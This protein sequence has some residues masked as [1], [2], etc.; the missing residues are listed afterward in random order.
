MLLNKVGRFLKRDLWRIRTKDLPRSHAF[1]ISPLRVVMLAFR[2]FDEDKCQLRA[3]A[4]TFYTLLSM[5]PVAAMAFGIAKGFNF[6]DNLQ[7]LIL[8][9]LEGQEEVATQIIGFANNLLNN[10]SSGLIA[11]IGVAILFWTVIKVLGNIEASFNDIWGVKKSRTMMRKFADYL[12]VMLI[13]PLLLIVSSSATIF[14]ATQVK[15]LVAKMALLGA[16][17]PLILLLLKL[18]PFVVIWVLFTFVYVFM[19]NTKVDFKAGLLGGITAGTIYQIAQWAY[20]TFQIGAS[21]YGAIYG[22]F[23]AL[24][25]FLVWLQISWLIVLLGAEVSFAYQNVETYSFEPDCLEISY[26][27]KRLLTLRIMC[28]AAKRF[29]SGEPPLTAGE[30]T[31][32]LDIP[33]R[34]V[35]QIL[36]ELVAAGLFAEVAP[37]EDKERTFQP[38]RCVEGLT[39]G[40]VMC[41]LEEK[42]STA[43]PVHDSAELRKLRESLAAF[44]QTIKASAANVRLVDV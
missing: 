5:V 28:L 26:S 15:L 11:G 27:F 21:K 39:L 36:F 22:S 3:S 1:F 40:D 30:F 9:R 8:E 14:V 43:I 42:G 37:R 44:E 10:T 31:H 32:V 7:K 4:L 38:S 24:P 41:M 17:A 18:L 25:L 16:V 12:S 19:P 34:L 35:R 2:G 20:V 6:Q 23:A 29:C 33:I 13:A